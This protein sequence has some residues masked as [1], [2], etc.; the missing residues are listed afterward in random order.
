MHVMADLTVGENGAVSNGKNE[1]IGLSKVI[2]RL[3]N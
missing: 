1:I 3:D 2:L